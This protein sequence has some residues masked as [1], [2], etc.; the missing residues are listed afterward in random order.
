[1]DA[2]P[3]ARQL[4]QHIATDI[5]P[6]STQ[7]AQAYWELETTGDEKWVKET[8]RLQT[9]VMKR[10]ANRDELTRLRELAKSSVSD[11]LLAREVVLWR[12]QEQ[13]NAFEDRLIEEMSRRSTELLAL[14]N[15]FRADLNGKKVGDNQIDDILANTTSSAEAEAAWRASKQVSHFHGEGDAGEPLYRR[16]L[17]LVKVRNEAARSQ[18]FANYYVMSLELGELDEASLFQTL[19]QLA[20]AT[21]TP[22]R[23][24]KEKLDKELAARF[25]IRRDELRP[26]HYGDR[27]FQSPPKAGGVDLDPLFKGKDVVALT[28]K[29][30]DGMGMDIRPIVQRSDLFPGD[31]ATSKKCQHAFCIA[32]RTPLDVRVLCNLTDTD[33]WMRT[34]LHEFGHAVY[35]AGIRAELPFALRSPS[36]TLTT[37]SIALM[38]ERNRY[39]AHWLEQ[40][41]GVARGEAQRL[42]DAGRQRLA[43]QHLIFTRWVLVMCHFERALYANPDRTDLNTLWWDLV[44][45]FQEV[46]RPAADHSEPDWASKIHFT[47][48]PAYYQNYLLGEVF[49]AQLQEAMAAACGGRWVLNPDAGRFLNDRMFACGASYRWDELLQRLTGKPMGVEAFLAAIG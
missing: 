14:F 31:P 2:T 19:D 32:I 10:L 28:L 5:E 15:G 9:A 13:A 12:N 30:Y 45:R 34:N 23:R 35:D 18:G 40:V 44:E 6:L 11:A 49:G 17:E 27:F 39:D 20:Q 8:E 29:T 16:L 4:C 46:R 37:E 42:Q 24:M 38:M 47:S 1:M 21:T 26:W 25:G 33:R 43:Q 48:S 3:Q 41:A 22:F 36:H 7:L